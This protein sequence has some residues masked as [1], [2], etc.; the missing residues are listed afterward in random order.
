MPTSAACAAVTD[1]SVAIS[2]FLYTAASRVV[3]G[4]VHD[5]HG[6][7]SVMGNLVRDRSE[8]ETLRSGHPFVADDDQVDALLL[9]HVD[10]PLRGISLPKNGLDLDLL[11][12]VFFGVAQNGLPDLLSR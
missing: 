11:R 1:P 7:R 2:T 6:A 3:S 4:R 5:Q 10:Q 8:E 12:E 9:G